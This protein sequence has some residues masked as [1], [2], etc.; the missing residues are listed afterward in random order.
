MESVVFDRNDFNKKCFSLI[1]GVDYKALDKSV[2]GDE[3][4]I[5]VRDSL[6]N[7]VTIAFE[8]TR[9]V[10]LGDRQRWQ[11]GKVLASDGIYR[12]IEIKRYKDEAHLDSVEVFPQAPPLLVQKLR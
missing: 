1:P 4:E 11:Y 8:V 6:G 2:L 9:N 12:Q 5:A 10:Y 7:D 3:V